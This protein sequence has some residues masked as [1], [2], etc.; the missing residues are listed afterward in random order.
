MGVAAGPMF[1]GPSDRRPSHARES[2]GR[3]SLTRV[4]RSP[5]TPRLR[6]LPCG[7]TPDLGSFRAGGFAR[8]SAPRGRRPPS[9]SGGRLPRQRLVRGCAPPLALQ[10]SAD[11]SRP[12]RRRSPGR[13]SGSACRVLRALPRPGF[14]GRGWTTQLDARPP[15]LRQPYGDCLLRR[16]GPVLSF[17]DVVHLFTHE[18]AGLRRRRLSFPFVLSGTS[19]RFLLRHALNPVGIECITRSMDWRNAGLRRLLK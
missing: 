11:R 7:G 10:G 16:A 3:R 17:T 19:H 18:F 12:P 8:R 1:A 5:P 9:R 15:R 14:R 13:S 2:V 6:G 4:R